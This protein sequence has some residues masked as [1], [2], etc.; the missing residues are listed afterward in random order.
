M[1]LAVS[2]M[3]IAICVLLHLL[4][5]LIVFLCRDN[6]YNQN[7]YFAGGQA[8]GLETSGRGGLLAQGN[9]ADTIWK[10]PKEPVTSDFYSI[11]ICLCREDTGECCD[12]YLTDELVVGRE[13]CGD[14]QGLLL[15][16]PTVSKRH[17]LIYRKGDQ[18]MLQDLD[19]TN[20]TFVNGFLVKG[21]VPVSHGDRIRMGNGVY[22][23]SCCYAQE[24][25]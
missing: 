21:A 12:A 13:A 15:N 18:V 6:H 11:Y 16:D 14:T 1:G 20:H 8:V 3:A 22:R 5:R 10:R 7:I 9:G 25:G 2:A 24:T 23:F 17:C 4:V 19:S